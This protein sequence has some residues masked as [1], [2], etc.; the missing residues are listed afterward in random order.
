MSSSD[1]LSHTHPMKTQMDHLMRDK[2]CCIINRHVC[3]VPKLVP[4][5]WPPLAPTASWPPLWF[6]W[7]RPSDTGPPPGGATPR[8]WTPTTPPN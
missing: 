8:F 5:S 4:A 6:L 2:S 3:R 1:S 7:S